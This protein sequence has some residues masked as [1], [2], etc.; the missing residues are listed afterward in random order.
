MP[1]ASQLIQISLI[2]EALDHGPALIFIA[3]EEMKFVAVNQLA[4]DTLGYPREEL[5]ELRVTDVVHS[6]SATDEYH[7]MMLKGKR[8]GSATLT[9]KDGN[10]IDFRYRATRTR[11]AQL[12]FFV[13]VGFADATDA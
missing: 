4:A 6:E 10:E 12:S 8:T 3:D 2:G 11:I 5:L 7:E 9:R 1:S 13:S